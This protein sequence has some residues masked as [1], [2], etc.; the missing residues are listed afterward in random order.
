MYGYIYK[1]TNHINGKIYIGQHKTTNDEID[2]SYYGSGLYLTR[3]IQKY[4]VENFSCEVICWCENKDELDQKEIEWIS[5]LNATDHSI[6]YN[7]QTGGVGGF[8]H[9]DTAGENNPMFGV[10]RHGED[11]PNYGHR[12]TDEQRLA[13]SEMIK[14]KGGHHGA[15]NPMFGKRHTPESKQRMIDAKRTEDG[16]YKYKGERAVNYGKHETHPCYGLKWW[17]DGINPPIKA[18]ECPGP[19]YH[20]GRK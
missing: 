17:C 14:N 3:A 6:G 8:S 4:G 2:A 5:L 11:N 12:W 19:Q 10:H 9:I 7:I 18:K 1:T 15:N 20:R 13:K 16:E